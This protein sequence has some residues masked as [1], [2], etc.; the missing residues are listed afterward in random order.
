MWG[1]SRYLEVEEGGYDSTLKYDSIKDSFDV[2]A[3][4]PQCV[5]VD[6]LCDSKTLVRGLNQFV[7]IRFGYDDQA[8]KL[9]Y[10]KGHYPLGAPRKLFRILDDGHNIRMMAVYVDR[11]APEELVVTDQ[12]NDNQPIVFESVEAS[13]IKS[14]KVVLLPEY[15]NIKQASVFSRVILQAT[16]EDGSV[17]SKRL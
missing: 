6:G 9:A 5:V 2:T 15:G 16:L 14:A 8:D 1:Y 12:L 11:I 10:G 17:L 3:V 13:R 7:S 4:Q